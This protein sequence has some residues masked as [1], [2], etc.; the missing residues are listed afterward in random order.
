MVITVLSFGDGGSYGLE[1]EEFGGW[2]KAIP[3]VLAT[4]LARAPGATIAPRGE[5]GAGLTAVTDGGAERMDAGSAA[6][7]AASLGAGFAV[8]GSFA[9][10]YGNLRID[11]RIVESGTGRIVSV[12]SATGQREE[13]FAL[14][15]AVADQI[16]P[17][18]G[19]PP[20]A[21]EYREP[22]ATEAVTLLGLG[23]VAEDRGSDSEAARFYRE[24]LA[25]SPSLTAA[26][27]ALGR[28]N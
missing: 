15:V 26:T 9:D 21:G 5:A 1:P 4:A 16:R 3:A 10:V 27:E 19:L 14:I 6:G 28:L 11:A 2:S 24:A 8:L 7:I 23:L 25:R 13:L 22:V 17:E 12:A 18:V 20:A